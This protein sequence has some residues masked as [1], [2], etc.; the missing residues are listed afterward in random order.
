MKISQFVN[1]A[2]FDCETGYYR[3]KNPLG[4]ENDFVTAPEI[5]QIFGEIIAAYLL[6]ICEGENEKFNLV[7]MGAGRGV[8]MRDV[9]NT[10]S[11]LAKK[12]I[13]SAQ[14]FLEK[15]QISIVEINSSLREVQKENLKEVLDC[16]VAQG[17][18]RNDGNGE[19]LQSAPRNDDEGC[20]RALIIWFENFE[21]FLQ[22]NQ[23]KIFFISNELFDCFA[24]D[25]YVFTEIGWRERVIIDGKFSLAEFDKKTNQEIESEV[26][27]LVPLGGV[28]EISNSA[29]KFM[30]KLS[31]A[32]FE[33]GGAAINFD[34][35]YFKNEFA[36]TLQALKN[37]RKVDIFTPSCDITAHV[38]FAA[39][40]LIAK[41]FNLNSSL[42]SQKDF[43]ISLGI[44]EREKIL[45]TQNPQKELEISAAVNRLIDENQMGE[46]FKIHII[47]K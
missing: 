20:E 7:E 11:K 41:K 25:Q 34:Y 19:G 47:W 21:D 1:K 46:L 35:G 42:I 32:L 26:D 10:I 4:A 12:N 14:N 37:H 31:K 23:G 13:V 18:P 9:L 44:K 27:K 6:Q 29:R 5:S 45:I 17:A 15:A 24:I 33:R 16:F 2:L 28:F 8:M 40:D 30:E 38:D 43:L 36:N 3:V 22:Q 39:L